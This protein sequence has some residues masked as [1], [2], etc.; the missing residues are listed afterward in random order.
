MRRVIHSE[1]KKKDK[2]ELPNIKLV[3]K[4]FMPLGAIVNLSSI[5][6]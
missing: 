6:R 5:H 4:A 2:R 3:P 1:K